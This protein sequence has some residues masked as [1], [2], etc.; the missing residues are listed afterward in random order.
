MEGV[1]NAS[2]QLKGGAI[3]GERRLL[4]FKEAFYR[5]ITADFQCAPLTWSRSKRL[6]D[7]RVLLA[8]AADCCRP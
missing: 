1:R 3:A 6:D 8:S 5:Q 7:L 2:E 4:A